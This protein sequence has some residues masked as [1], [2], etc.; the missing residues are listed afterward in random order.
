M[1]VMDKRLCTTCGPTFEDMKTSQE[2]DATKVIWQQRGFNIADVLA[3]I[4][5]L[6]HTYILVLLEKRPGYLYFHYKRRLPVA[7]YNF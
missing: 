2:N 7:I 1:S 4:T 3:F 6:F 5:L